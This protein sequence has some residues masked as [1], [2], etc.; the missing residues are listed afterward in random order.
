[1]SWDFDP[2]RPIYLQLVDKLKVQ[3]ASGELAPGEKLIPVRELAL[4]AGVNPNTLQRALMELERENLIFSQRTTGRFVTEDTE[5]IRQMAEKLAS[6]QISRLI[7]SLMQLGYEKKEIFR[8][9]EDFFK[10]EN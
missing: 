4:T 8:L 7:S 1:M 3:I 2:D 5:A 10:E 9:I 6:E